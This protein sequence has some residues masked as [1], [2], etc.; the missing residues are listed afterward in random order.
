MKK[1]LVASFC[2]LTVFVNGYSQ[3]STAPLAKGQERFT[4]KPKLTRGPYLQV[5][6]DTSIVIRWRTDALSRGRVR[7]GQDMNNL[8]KTVDSMSLSTEH[9]LKI[10]GLT[11]GT[12]YYYSIGTIK[13][14]LQYGADNYFSTLP[15]PGKEGFYRIGVF[16]DCG[17]PSINQANVRDQFIRYLGNN[18]LNA[19]ILLGD[20][21]YND[22]NDMEYQSKFFFPYKDNLLKKYPLYPTPGNHDYHD[23]DLTVE[24]GQ[25]THEVPYYFNFSMPT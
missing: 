20:N 17:Y 21:A 4:N 24:Y 11:A 7:Y 5:A 22:G 9:E 13:D 2:F 3:N 8:S 14:T 25:K 16:G 23:A 10:T 1:I 12:K 15:V 19:W 18:D 6:T